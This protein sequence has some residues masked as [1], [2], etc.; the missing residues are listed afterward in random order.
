VPTAQLSAAVAVPS[1]ASI[2]APV[3][4]HPNTNVVPVAVINGASESTVQVTV[5]ETEI[6]GFPQASLTLKVLVCEKRQGPPVTRPS[7][8]MG[9]PTAQL[10]AAVAVPRAE[11][12][13]APDGLHPNANVVPV[14]VI[15]GTSESTVQVTVRDTGI[16][17]LPQSSLTLNVLVCEKRHGP[18]VTISSVGTGVPTEQLS[19]AV[20]VPSAASISA[21]VGLH[22]SAK[23][24]P[25]AVITGTSE[26]IDQV[27]V[28]ETDIAGF[29]QASVTSN[30]L[31]CDKRQG[32]PV[33]GPSDD[34]GVPTPQSSSAVAVPSA[35]SMAAA[36]GL[37]PNVNVVPVAVMTGN[38]VSNVQV[39]VRETGIA[40]LPH[41]SVTLN[42]LVCE[43]R[44]TPVILPS[45]EIG[46]PT[47]QL[48]VAVAVPSVESMAAAEGLHPNTK[49]VPVAVITG[50]SESNDQV[51]VR[52][53]DIAG[54]PQSSITLKVLVWDK[55]QGSPVTGPSEDVGVPTPQS[56]DA[57]AVPSAE[58]MAAADGIHPNVN[59][60]PIA[61]MTGRVVSRVHVTVR[62]TGTAG[63]PHSSMALKVLVCDTRHTPVMLPSVEVGVTTEQLSDAVAVPRAES[64][65]APDGL[66]PN[67]KVVPDAVITG[68]EPS[69]LVV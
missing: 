66:H 5:R 22:P 17:G 34:V 35:E 29:P 58:S 32:A 28:R 13:A 19:D 51:T 25:V 41:A 6:A 56:S 42:V 53:T 18:P 33:T 48:S 9:V 57:V 21:P 59:V 40:G 4:L 43:T 47:V 68:A 49:V 62:D 30:V 15:T 14:A 54:F 55:R 26:S 24:V 52:D 3:G 39:T 31:V 46:V 50:S 38:V 45:V 10:S 16:A 8:G 64:I 44:H 2:S 36:E 65:A 60:V 61:V 7:D 37:H 27:T 1:A 67:D 63:F 11:S 20:A 69:I 12:I 23:V